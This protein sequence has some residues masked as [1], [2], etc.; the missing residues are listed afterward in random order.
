MIDAGKKFSNV[1]LQN[2]AGLGIVFANLTAKT[3]ETIKRFMDTLAAAAGK[4]IGNKYSVKKWIK[5][6]INGVMQ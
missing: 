6:A 5:Q 1:A 4:R 3:A 2:P